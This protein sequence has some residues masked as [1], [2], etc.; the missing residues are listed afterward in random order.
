MLTQLA[1]CARLEALALVFGGWISL[2]YTL[3][4]IAHDALKMMAKR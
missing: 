2:A 1:L 3:K 4:P